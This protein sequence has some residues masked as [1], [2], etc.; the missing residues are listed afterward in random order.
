MCYSQHE[1]ASLEMFDYL[2]E[3]NNLRSLLLKELSENDL[4]FIKELIKHPDPDPTDDVS[5]T[6]LLAILY[7]F[8]KCTYIH[9]RIF[10]FKREWLV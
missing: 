9:T 1:D 7:M 8:I 6:L 2:I 10:E 4:V 5:I 3:R